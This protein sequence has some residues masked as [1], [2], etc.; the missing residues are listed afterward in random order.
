MSAQDHD[1][2]RKREIQERER[3]EQCDDAPARRVHLEMAERYSALL[4]DSL[5][6]QL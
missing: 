3:A 1:Y 2:Y 4:R 6:P 5:V